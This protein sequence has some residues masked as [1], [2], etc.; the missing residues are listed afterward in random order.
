[1]ALLEDRRKSLSL[2]AP[3][4]TVCPRLKKKKV[5]LVKNKTNGFTD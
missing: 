3:E 5:F 1:M 2:E 4:T